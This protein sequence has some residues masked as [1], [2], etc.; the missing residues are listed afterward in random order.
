MRLFFDIYPR[1]VTKKYLYYPR[2]VTMTFFSY[3]CY[4]IKR[5]IV[6]ELK[7]WKL[8]KGRKPLVLRGARQVGKTTAVHLFAESFEQYIYLNLEKEK[9]RQLFEKFNSM[10]ELVQAIFFYKNKS[11]LSSDTLIF[12]DEIQEVPEALTKLRYF[13]EDYPQYYVI[14]A[15]SLLESLF[16]TQVSF[17]VGRVEYKVLRPLSFEE[18][19][20][21]MEETAALEQYYKIPVASFAH[22]RLLELFHLYTLIGGMPEI[23]SKYIETKDLIS[24]KTIY[25][26]LILSYIDDVE[27]YTSTALQMNIMRH[28]IRSCFREAGNRIKFQGFGESAYASREMGEALRTLEKAMLINL[29]YPTTQTMYP[30]MP[31]LKRSP[32]LQV[33]DTGM[34]NYFSGVQKQLFGTKDL[35]TIYQGHIAEHI[36]GQELLAKQTSLLNS[37]N[38]WVREKK[39]SVAEL[40]YLLPYEDTMIP[41]E[42][43]SGATGR[44]RSLHQFMEVYHGDVA[45]RLYAGNYSIDN[46]TSPGGKEYR[47]VNMPYYLAGVIKQYISAL[48]N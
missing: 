16:D 37:L 36:V 28:A 4:M 19:L 40:D 18:F 10:D 31:D 13:Y 14:A 34:L 9:D 12:I 8:S 3:L 44:L 33:L 17:P 20:D 22:E 5:T 48:I 11:I 26:S 43:K 29:I 25:E 32:R 6:E 27:K 38:F 23:V 35:N 47:L 41:V 46:L 45:V 2:N 24:L 21:A 39:D 42:V 7:S 15:G 30:F 1:N